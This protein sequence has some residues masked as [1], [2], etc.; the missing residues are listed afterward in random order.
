[1]LSLLEPTPDQASRSPMLTTNG[2]TRYDELAG[3]VGST[4]QKV[5]S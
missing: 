2:T 4:H 5:R 3:G 1:M